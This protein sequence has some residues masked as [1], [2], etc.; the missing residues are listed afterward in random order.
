MCTAIS[1]L[2][3]NHYFGRNLDMVSAYREEVTI[4]PKNYVFRFRNGLNIYHHYAMIGM[5]TVANGYPLYYEATNEVGLSMVGLNFPDNAIYLPRTACK[6]NI[7]P[8]EM[9]P[10]VLTQCATVQEARNLLLRVNVWMLPFSREYMLTP[11]HWLVADKESCLVV[12]S[13]CD[14]VKLYDNPVGVLTNSPAFPYHMTNLANYR[15]LQPKDVPGSFCGVPIP[16]YSGGMG[17]MGLP[18]DYSSASRFVKAAY[19]RCNSK[20]QG[21]ESAHVSQFFHI[22]NAVA[23]PRGT[24]ELE[25]GPE[26]TLYSS[27]CNTDKGIYYYTTYEN[28]RITAVD[29]HHTNLNMEALTTYP[30]RKFSEIFVQN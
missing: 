16:A 6:D 14:G 26:V 29:M 12:E 13:T 18:G 9:I 22:L 17:A 2:Q 5:A 21:P 7:A 20:S 4:T 15:H 10:W 11:M 3:G 19:L 25:D 28:S 24:V 27:C 8:F 1:Y 23:M 30:L